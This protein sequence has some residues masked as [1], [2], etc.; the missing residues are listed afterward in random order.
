VGVRATIGPLTP[1]TVPEITFANIPVSKSE[2]D[3]ILSLRYS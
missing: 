2:Y 3:G 1:K